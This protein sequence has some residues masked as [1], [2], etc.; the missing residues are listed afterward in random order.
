MKT[1]L[2]LSVDK[3]LVQYAR[4]QAKRDG[5]SVSGIFSDYLRTRKLQVEKKS[6]PSVTNMVGVLKHYAIDDSKAAIKS[7]YAR[8]YLSR[9]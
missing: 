3:E 9:S 8:K 6:F 2:T 5:R 1:K 7:A 4:Q